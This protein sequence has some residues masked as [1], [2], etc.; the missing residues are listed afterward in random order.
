M[1][2]DAATLQKK[3]AFDH[4]AIA[5]S[6]AS[7]DRSTGRRA[8]PA[9]QRARVR[10]RRA[11]VRRHGRYVALSRARRRV[12]VLRTRRRS[13]R[14][15]WTRRRRRCVRALRRRT[16][17]RRRRSRPTR[18]ACRRTARP[19]RPS[20]TSTCSRAPVGARDWTPLSTDGSEANAYSIQSLSWSPDSKK[21]AAYRVQARLQARSALRDV[22]SR[23]SDPAEGRSSPVQ[24]ARRRARRGPAGAVRHGDAQADGD[25]ERAVSRTRTR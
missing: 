17:W 12:A 14:A 24:Q 2:A 18:R 8:Q 20:A 1:V 6:L 9:V 3:P 10:R 16:L 7:G 25:L 23:G 22:E 11:L 13:R 5:A 21:L 19:K 15:R 4:A